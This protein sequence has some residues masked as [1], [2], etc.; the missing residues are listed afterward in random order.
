MANIFINGL[1][2]KV[3]GGKSIF[4]NYLALLNNSKL[5]HTYFILTPD[6]NVYK[7]YQTENISVIDIPVFFK[8]TLLYPFVYGYY[9]NQILKKYNIDVV[10][11]LADIPIKTIVKQVYLF[12]WSYAVYPDSVVWKMMDFKSK[13]SRK[14][15]LYFFK[16]HLKY[17]DLLLSQTPTMRKRLKEIYGVNNIEVVPNAVSIDNLEAKENHKFNLPSGIK[18]LYLTHY[19]PHKNL[20]IFIPLAKKIKDRQLPYKLITT[21]DRSQHK[22]AKLFLNEV[23]ASNLEDIIINIGSVTMEQVPSL[24]KQCDGLLMPTL[25]E[26]F[27]G[28]YVEAMYHKIPIFTSNIDFASGVCKDAAI[29]FEPFDENEILNCI[30]LVFNDEVLKESKIK[31][32]TKVLNNLPDWKQAYALYNKFINQ[33]LETE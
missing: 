11:N 9:L 14:T 3:G 20:E 28:T 33:A 32:G 23:K 7:K 17:I 2:A 4:S 10:F 5:N 26:S 8:N 13:L 24:Y 25:L 6:V 16:K 12:D 29:Y 30:E 27:S 31:T 18:L 21:I 19:Y 1:N 15:K 22:G